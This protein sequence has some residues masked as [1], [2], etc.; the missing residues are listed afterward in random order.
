MTKEKIEQA[1]KALNEGIIYAY[2][3]SEADI[4]SKVFD[5]NQESM[6]ICKEQIKIWFFQQENEEELLSEEDFEE[7]LESLVFY[8]YTGKSKPKTISEAIKLTIGKSFWGPK[9]VWLKGKFFDTYGIPS[10]DKNGK[11]TGIRF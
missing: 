8:V 4:N 2:D 10:K 11:I 1:K 5:Y 6:E 3:C 9:H 7:Y